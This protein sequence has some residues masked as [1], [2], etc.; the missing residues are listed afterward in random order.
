MAATDGLEI[1]T[2]KVTA[3]HICAI[4]REEQLLLMAN[5]SCGIKDY[6]NSLLSP[7]HFLDF[8]VVQAPPGDCLESVNAVSH[9]VPV[10]KK[11]LRAAAF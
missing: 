11:R 2:H 6:Y 7:K 9:V 3:H 4:T 8:I 5:G 10:G 1:Q